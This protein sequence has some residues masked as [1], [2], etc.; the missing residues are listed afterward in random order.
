M[1]GK[2]KSQLSI[3]DSAFNKRKKQSRSDDLL[4][5]IERFVDWHRLEK[6]VVQVYKPSKRG[7]PT[8]PI[9]Y[10][11]KILFLQYLYNLSD[12][13]L[14]DALIDRLSFQRFVGFGFDEDI[15]NFSTIW[16][17]RER[18]IKAN[19]LDNLFNLIVEMLDEKGFVL[20][21]GTL[22]DATI[23]NASRKYNN[24]KK[25]P[26]AQQDTD[27]NTT[28]KGNKSYY[29]YKGHVGVDY[30]SG[31]I[32]KAQFTPAN[33]HDSDV[34]DELVSGDESSVF[35]DKAYSKKKRK[36]KMRK[37]GV[38][39]GILDKGYRDHPLSGSQ[40]KSN[41]KKSKV[42]NAVERVFAHLKN[43]YGYRR[44]RYV[45]KARNKLQFMF[46]CMIYNIRRGLAL[47]G[48]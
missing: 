44:V 17:F 3:L 21:K 6:E 38:Y 37:E 15:P 34:Y 27:A 2:P 42:R 26:N 46:L 19:I 14:E 9:I 12:P 25:T 36:Q 45:N 22:V 39:Y 47:S 5:K 40:K 30:Q 32:R 43:L 33:V 8:I 41:K 35:A 11:L 10:M 28:A 16:R 29:G 20:R 7:R 18:L 31:I 1:I 24:K 13:A 4:R 48:A 23:V